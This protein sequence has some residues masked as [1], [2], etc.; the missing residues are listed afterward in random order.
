MRGEYFVNVVTFVAIQC[1]NI[2]IGM[3]IGIICA[4][5]VF[6]VG[7][8]KAPAVLIPRIKRRLGLGSSTDLLLP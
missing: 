8:S 6:A 7:Y 4:L 1:S 3:T 2:E 5:A